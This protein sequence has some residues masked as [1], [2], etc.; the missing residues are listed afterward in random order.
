MK[1]WLLWLSWIQESLLLYEV[2]LLY[3]IEI[4]SFRDGD[5]LNIESVICYH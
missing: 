5:I 1:I 4:E 3:Y 2:F